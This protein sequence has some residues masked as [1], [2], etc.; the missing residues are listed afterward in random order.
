MYRKTPS[1]LAVVPREDPRH[2][3]WNNIVSNHN[4]AN[5]MVVD[6]KILTQIA[7]AS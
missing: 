3:P 2:R 4:V 7:K 1:M 6:I 5:A